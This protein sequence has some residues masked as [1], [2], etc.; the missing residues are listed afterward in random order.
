MSSLAEVSADDEDRLSGRFWL[1]D[2]PDRTVGGW[3][4]LVGRWPPLELAEPL[5]PA[6]KE[7]ARDEQPDGSVMTTYEPADDDVEPTTTTIHGLLRKGPRRRVTLIET[8][9]TGR[10]QVFGTS[11]RDPGAERLEAAYALVGAHVDDA[12]ALFMRAGFVTG[13]W[14]HGRRCLESRWRYGP[15]AVRL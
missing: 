9:N 11:V 5:T 3:L 12:E 2:D 15:T 13:T 10:E 7:I 1:P 14:I 6:L 8:F 4:S